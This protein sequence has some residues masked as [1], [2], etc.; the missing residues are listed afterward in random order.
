MKAPK[1]VRQNENVRVVARTP[2]ELFEEGKDDKGKYAGGKW[3]GLYLRAP[4]IYFRIL[5]KAGDKLVRLGEV[6][7][8]RFGIKTGANDFFYLEP[9]SYHP[10]CPLCKEVHEDVL[11]AEEERDYW[12]RGKQ[13]PENKLVAVRNEAGW[14]GYVEARSLKPIIKSYRALTRDS[15]AIPSLRLF[16]Y[17][18][19]EHSGAYLRY[20]EKIC[21]HQRASV[22]SRSPWWKLSPLTPPL[23]IV[24]AGV[25]RDYVFLPNKNG[26]L[27]DKRLYGLFEV[28]P[29]VVDLMN[30]AL[31][32]LSLEVLV[33]TG[34]GGG[35][36]DFTVYEYGQG[37]LLNPKLLPAPNTKVTDDLVADILGLTTEERQELL[38][39]LERLI[40][41]RVSRANT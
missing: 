23:A 8:I 21:V 4:D 26:F 16:V 2:A 11:T 29:I 34:L 7:K 28:K 13:P 10:F 36:A 38:C 5:E 27:V 25:N 30:T 41:E 18:E 12:K 39:A 14:E 33:R 1:V 40:E 24:P 22:S 3:G 9:L 31:F 35:L 32:K 19:G 37:L 20:G 6:A 15:D 17:A